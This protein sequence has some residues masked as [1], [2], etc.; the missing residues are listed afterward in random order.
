MKILGI[1]QRVEFISSHDER[2]DC[3]DQRWSILAYHLGYIPVPLPN[4]P[5]DKIFEMIKFL[6]IDA[7]IFSGGNSIFDLENKNK[8]AAPE[9]DLFEKSLLKEALKHKIP[10]LGICRGMQMINVFFG[11][12]L[13]PVLNHVGVDHELQ[14]DQGYSNYISK[15]VNSYHNWGIKFSEM[16]SGFIPIAKDNQNNVEAFIHENLSISGIM[17]HPERE[18][19]FNEKNLRLIK[20]LLK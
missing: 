7:I 1:T 5:N 19:P 12:K 13:S 17:W 4:N 2:R 3:L 11:G 8:D 14:L 20:R 10:I 15:K 18:N 16:A 6:N 9:R